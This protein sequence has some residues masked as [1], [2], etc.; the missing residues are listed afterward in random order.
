MN[1]YKIYKA[2]DEQ[3]DLDNTFSNEIELTEEEIDFLNNLKK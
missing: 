1:Y 3:T 2:I